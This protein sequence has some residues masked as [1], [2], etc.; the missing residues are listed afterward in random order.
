MRPYFLGLVE[1]SMAIADP[2]PQRL[3]RA[4]QRVVGEL[5]HRRNPL[6]DGGIVS[7]LA[8]PEQRAVLDR[9]QAL[10]TL[11]E[12]HGNLVMDQLG[13][14][15]VHGQARMAEAL[16]TRRQQG[17]MTRQIFK[18]LGLEMKMRQY[19][20][21]ERFCLA[22]T[23]LA[24]PRGLDAAWRS[25]EHLPTLPEIADPAAW[26]TRVDSTARSLAR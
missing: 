22:V 14:V 11:L 5:R 12:G 20:V 24:G 10:M 17:G 21:G 13:A 23:D 1:E 8:S 7:L 2:D 6:D 15:H 9:V 3:T 4:V 16:K 26:L 25:P 19:E 18:A